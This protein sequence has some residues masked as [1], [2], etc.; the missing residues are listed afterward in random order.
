MA[1]LWLV[2]LAPPAWLLISSIASFLRNYAIARKAKHVPFGSGSFSRFS[3]TGWW[4]TERHRAS[5]E[6]GDTI[7]LVSPG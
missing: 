6:H 5:M 1:W 4:W 2:V 3:Y 7:L